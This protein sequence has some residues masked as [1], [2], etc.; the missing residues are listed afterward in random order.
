MA[1]PEAANPVCEVEVGGGPKQ[2]RQCRIPSL[3]DV[4][5]LMAECDGDIPLLIETLYTT[6]MRISEAAGLCVKDLDFALGFASVRRRD[7]R[8]DVGDTKSEEGTRLL[9]LGN[10]LEALKA[11]V[12]AKNPEDRVFTHDGEPIVDNH[13][14]TKFLDPRLS[15]SGLSS[16]ASAGI[17][18]AVYT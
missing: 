3:Q 1:L 4:E 2:I 9:P 8:G 18:S 11:H 12:V 13:L 14:L 6:G 16:P 10:A 15:S 17:R 7:Y 5:R